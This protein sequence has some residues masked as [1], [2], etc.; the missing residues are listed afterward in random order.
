[1]SKGGECMGTG[2]GLPDLANKITGYA[3]KFEYQINNENFLIQYNNVPN[4]IW[5]I[6]I[7][8]NNSLFL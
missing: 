3:I 4:N 6:L 1:M 8:L 5:N 7:F 2:V